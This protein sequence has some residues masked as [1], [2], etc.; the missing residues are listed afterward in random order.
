[1]DNVRLSA[2]P[3]SY[4]LIT[5]KK[6]RRGDAFIHLDHSHYIGGNMVKENEK[7]GYSSPVLPHKFHAGDY[8]W[9]SRY[10]NTTWASILHL[11]YHK[12]DFRPLMTALDAN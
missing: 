2:D 12:S 11:Y 9:N 1:M 3:E 4:Q 10:F 7:C 6:I 8:P 5:K